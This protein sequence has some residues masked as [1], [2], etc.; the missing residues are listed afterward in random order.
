M[1]S[2][3]TLKFVSTI[4]HNLWVTWIAWEII[5]CRLLCP[6]FEFLLYAWV[7]CTEKA[8]GESENSISTRV[9]NIGLKSKKEWT[10]SAFNQMVNDISTFIN[11]NSRP[12]NTVA[13]FIIFIECLRS[14]TSIILIIRPKILTT[15]F[16]FCI[17]ALKKW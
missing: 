5:I 16:C 3:I 2:E 6:N 7:E 1:V 17:I 9:I 15:T 14:R 11:G 10:P 13:T 4:L 8:F 12:I